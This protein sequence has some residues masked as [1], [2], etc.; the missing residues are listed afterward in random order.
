MSDSIG[1][2]KSVV[3]RSNQTAHTLEVELTQTKVV[4]GPL[5]DASST[6]IPKLGVLQWRA[7][8][9]AWPR[10][11]ASARRRNEMH[12]EDLMKPD[13]FSG[14]VLLSSGGLIF[15]SLLLIVVTA[16]TRA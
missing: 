14:I 3:D 2:F 10:G 8:R 12:P 16:F 15:V 11:H 1:A 9:Q 13:L 7:P 4:R 5:P 6:G